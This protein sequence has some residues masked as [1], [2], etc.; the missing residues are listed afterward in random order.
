METVI[1]TKEG[2]PNLGIEDLEGVQPIEKTDFT[3]REL[4]DM[5]I[6]EIPCL[7]DPIFIKKGIAVLVG[8]S[9]AGKSS[10]LRQMAMSVAGGRDFLG[11]K[12]NADHYRAYY[13]SSEDDETI[14]ARV[15]KTYN[16]TMKL[17]PEAGENLTFFFEINP[18]TIAEDVDDKLAESPA[19]L[20]IIDAFADAFCGKSLNDSKEVRAFYSKFTP[21]ANKYNCLILFNHHTGKRTGNYG[22]DKDNT[23]GSQ[24]I[25]A[26][27]RLAIELRPD[28][29]DPDVKHFCVTKCN[30]LSSQYKTSSYALRMDE[31]FVFVPTGERRDYAEL[32]RNTRLVKKSESAHEVDDAKHKDI[33]IS[34]FD[35]ANG[36][37]FNQSQLRKKIGEAFGLSD[38]TARKY[39]EYY[40]QKK[41]VER[42]GKEGLSILYKS[43]L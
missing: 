40:E 31:N 36:K 39:L 14:T 8:P 27:P 9:D 5:D 21:I 34:I 3:L 4:F 41:W 18:D 29:E 2:R 10:L 22:P 24:S 13:F 43:T 1:A 19:D 6:P 11:W 33:I 20:V 12:L 38:K 25:E 32:G 37:R 42:D 17:P 16:K 15:V 23:L 28:P 35:D 30:Y 7:F 26:K